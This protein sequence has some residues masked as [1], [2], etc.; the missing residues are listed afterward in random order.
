[1]ADRP[2][3]DAANQ[4]RNKG[5][6]FQTLPGSVNSL[7]HSVGDYVADKI[8]LEAEMI[9]LAKGVDE[10]GQVAEAAYNFLRY[11]LIIGRRKASQSEGKG[12]FRVLKG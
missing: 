9:I 12:P 3:A 7:L 5:E 1:M 6:E 8:S 11:S 10:L 2:I 4:V